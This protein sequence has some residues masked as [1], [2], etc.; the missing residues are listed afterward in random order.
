M[1]SD[2]TPSSNKP[3]DRLRHYL[4][5]IIYGANDGIITT[6]AVVSGVEGARLMPLI[7]VIL[8]FVNLFADGISMGASRYLSIRSAA[9]V[10]DINRGYLEPLYHAFTTFAAFFIFGLCPLLSFLI[11]GM[12]GHRFIV[13]I[14]ITAIS[15]FFVGS[16]RIF[17]SKK[18][19]YQGGFEMLGI[20]GMAAIIA[21]SVGYW[22]K[23]LIS[24]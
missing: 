8:G 15:L 7:V 13:S 19:W 16:L 9:A 2:H 24:S 5:D 22:I 17:I 23:A 20:G 12:V 11:P 3:V 10:H 6:F 18:R 4:G 1:Y 14:L 21:Y